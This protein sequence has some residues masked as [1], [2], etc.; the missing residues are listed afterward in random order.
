[1][2]EDKQLQALSLLSD[3]ESPPLHFPLQQQLAN[4]SPKQTVKM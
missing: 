2:G 3:F 1:M 4:S